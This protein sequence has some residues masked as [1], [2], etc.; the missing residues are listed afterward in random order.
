MLK[1]RTQGLAIL[2]VLVPLVIGNADAQEIAGTFDQLRVLVKAGDKVRVVDDAGR[3]TAGTIAEL[4]PASLGLLVRGQR[5]DL[6]AAEINTI[7]QRR[8]D[9]LA[10]GAKWGF[11]VGAGLGLLAGLALA[12][13][14]DEGDDSALVFFGA[15]IYG[16]IGAGIGAGVDALISTRQVIYARRAASFRVT[17][18]PL[19]TRRRQGAMVA[20]GF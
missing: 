11:G 16:G 10:N 18:R 19:L 9:S 3:E 7:T 14:Y 2:L 4:S 12:S 1:L 17:V 8:S 6:T 20:V 13:E 5:R 15:L